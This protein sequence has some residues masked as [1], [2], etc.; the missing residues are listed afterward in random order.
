MDFKQIVVVAWVAFI[1]GF[2]LAETFGY[3]RYRHS[4]HAWQRQW[5]RLSR[6]RPLSARL[7]GLYFNR[8]ESE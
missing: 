1:G 5:R 4:R 8:R 7:L 2:A 3:L 6:Q